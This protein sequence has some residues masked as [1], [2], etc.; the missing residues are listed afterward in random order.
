MFKMSVRKVLAIVAAFVLTAGS[1]QA[2]LVS[3]KVTGTVINSLD[4]DFAQ[5]GDAVTMCYTFESTA[6]WATDLRRT[7]RYA[8]A[9]V[10]TH[11]TV[12]TL[13]AGGT[14][15]PAGSITVNEAFGN[16]SASMR[17]NDIFISLSLTNADATQ[18][19]DSLPLTPL[20]VSAF[21][22]HQILVGYNGHGTCVATIDSMT[23]CGDTTPPT[24]DCSLLTNNILTSNHKLVDVGLGIAVSDDQDDNPTVEVLVYSDEPQDADGD[25]NTAEDAI[26][27]GETLWLRAERSGGGD[28]R[29]YLIV[30]IATDA[31][32]NVGFD[33]CTVTV[34]HDKSKA[35][36]N[37]VDQQALA[38][39]AATLI[40]GAAPAGFYPLFE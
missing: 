15:V 24:V 6:A 22:D 29:V 12:G 9:V 10:E 28:G 1:A 5:N 17:F 35:S 32:G 7:R 4:A 16:Y 11:I 18:S 14:L 30:V 21:K 23:F 37:S 38:A 20:D 40:D 34:P 39:E 27:D 31:A 3:F 2:E 26:D 19:L 13:D 25:G 33:C 36:R 8:D